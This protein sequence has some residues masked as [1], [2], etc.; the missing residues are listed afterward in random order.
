M[1]R[2]V[3]LVIFGFDAA[4]AETA[5]AA[6][7]RGQRVLVVTRAR[8]AR[9][10]RDAIRLLR[11]HRTSGQQ[12]VL[13]LTDSEVVCADGIER[14]EAVVVRRITTGRLIEFN[15][16]AMLLAGDEALRRRR[17]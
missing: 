9:L 17:T 6:A 8:R 16:S 12:P 14:L 3:D 11:R 2:T 5:I 15:A 10:R 1:T 7:Q 13:V 4:A